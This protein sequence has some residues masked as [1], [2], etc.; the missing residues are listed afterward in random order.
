MPPFPGF[1]DTNVVPGG[2]NPVMYGLRATP[3]PRLRVRSRNVSNPFGGATP[4]NSC[5]IWRSAGPPAVAIGFVSTPL[6]LPGE[7]SS[8]SGGGTIVAALITDPRVSAGTS[9]TI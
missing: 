9:A 3:D 5:V 1:T 7:G 6:L 8:T 4:G 2:I